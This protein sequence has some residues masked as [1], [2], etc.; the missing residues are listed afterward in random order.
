VVELRVQFWEVM[1]AVSGGEKFQDITCIPAENIGKKFQLFEV[2]VVETL[3]RLDPALEWRV[4]QVSGDQ[5]VD[6]RGAGPRCE[7]GILNLTIHQ[8]LLGQ[9]KRRAAGNVGLFDD[10]LRKVGKIALSEHIS[11]VVFVFSSEAL[12]TEALY[13]HF[14][15]PDNSIYFRGAK[16][17][18]DARRFEDFW[19]RDRAHILKVLERCLTDGQRQ[20]VDDYLSSIA[21]TSQ[22]ELAV[23]L[24]R[25][26]VG[27]TGKRFRCHLGIS[28]RVPL[29]T[30]KVR[31]RY[32]PSP[33]E[34]SKF[35]VLLPSRL[36]GPSQELFL[37]GEGV[38]EFEFFLR[39]FVAGRRRLGSIRIE[40]EAGVLI[41]SVELGERD[42]V[43]TFEPPYYDK[44][45]RGFHRAVTQHLSGAAN[46]EVHTLAVLGAGG[47]GK[48]RFCDAV[49][50]EAANLGFD[51]L[52][53]GHDNSVKARRRLIRVLITSLLPAT[54]EGSPYE[55]LLRWLPGRISPFDESQESALRTYFAEDTEG[56]AVDV[57]T[58]TLLTLIIER[59]RYRPLFI[60]LRDLHW[61]DGETLS[62]LGNAIDALR[63]V[64]PAAHGSVFLLEG[65]DRDSLR[66]QTGMFRPPEDWLAFLNARGYERLEIPP[67]TAAQSR[68]FL[69]DMIESARDPS[70]GAP[71]QR[72]PMFE[73]LCEH[74]LAASSGNPMHLIEQLK[75]LIDREYV[76]VT[77]AGTIYLKRQIP[78][79]WQPAQTVEDL[80]RLRLEFLK[81]RAPRAAELL[82]VMA[83]IGPRVPGALFRFV[84]G[85][86]GEDDALLAEL[87][88]V[89]MAVIPRHDGESLEFRHE[90]YYQVCRSTEVS[91][92]AVYLAAA[93]DF[94]RSQTALTAKQEF[95]AAFLMAHHERPDYESLLRHV[96]HGQAESKDAGD[97]LLCLDFCK[98][99]LNL[100]ENITGQS[101]VDR[102][103]VRLEQGVWQIYSGNWEESL[104]SLR[105]AEAM[106]A[107]RPLTA[108]VIKRRL[109]CKVDIVDALVTLMRADEALKEVE[110]G[111]QLI[112]AARTLQGESDADFTRDM[113]QARDRLWLRRAVTQWFD[114][115]IVEAAKWQRR[116]YVSGRAQGD[117]LTVGEALREFGTLILHRSPFFGRHVLDRAVGQLGRDNQHQATILARVETLFADLLLATW[118]N[119]D[120]GRVAETRE[121]AARL[122]YVCQEKASLYEAALLALVT[123]ACCALGGDL[124]DAHHWFRLAITTA[125][126][127]S[128]YEEIWKGRLNLSQ[129]CL[130]LG[131]TAE[132]KIHATEAAETLLVGLDAGSWA[133]R[134]ARRTMLTWP[135]LQCIRA[136]PG[137]EGRLS[138]YLTCEV[139]IAKQQW[140]QRPTVA[141]RSSKAIQVLHVRRGDSDYY[142]HN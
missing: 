116:A 11:G 140:Q 138:R 126:R 100:P 4:T 130:E 108:P 24:S 72:L 51:W 16:Y 131:L 40:T 134:A 60:H 94:Y 26:A 23:E 121:R 114:G 84:R 3:N 115:D 78:L 2:L 54:T 13:E 118:V 28:Q 47:A 111:L 37:S 123:G 125:M 117:A 139:D 95:E 127:T 142:F 88:R 66:L 48:S 30:L 7:F 133:R 99:L 15:D 101:G 46:G 41:K 34:S 29:P 25:D 63:D 79:D 45:N 76:E 89:D 49:I 68:D 57:V 61:A 129:I 5:G 85:H 109:S 36:A 128:S 97:N 104:E 65:R 55:Q 110:D 75:S 22:V 119:E 27:R 136:A 124:E 69:L 132:A 70:E 18:V 53:I 50:E 21:Y 103:E 120:A 1:K 73:Q 62:I 90:N 92:G 91:G 80:I 43:R 98:F 82:L 113:F 14:R 87:H 20:I 38:T 56:V 137:L 96:R 71:S 44:P 19:A 52:S 67:W 32:Q 8:N 135:L 17:F 86:T 31:L 102:A 107:R 64:C 39:C 105:E 81:A 58:A 77:D 9:I 83:K 6:F 42:F 106:F 112:A 59:T 74:I 12:S 35:E 141:V 93:I 33:S 122:H 10:D